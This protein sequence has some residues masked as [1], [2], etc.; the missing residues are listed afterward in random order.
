MAAKTQRGRSF[1]HALTSNRGRIVYQTCPAPFT[2]G[3][4]YQDPGQ[5]PKPPLRMTVTIEV[6]NVLIIAVVL[7]ILVHYATSG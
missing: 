5:E 4:M 6:W 1:R 7:L 3:V 2:P